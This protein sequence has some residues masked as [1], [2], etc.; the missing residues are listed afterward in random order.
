MF[1]Q[2][3]VGEHVEMGKRIVE[4]LRKDHFPIM[5]AFWYR[6]PDSGFWRLVIGSKLIDKIGGLEGYRRLHRILK[7][8]GAM[9]SFSGSISLFGSY[10]FRWEKESALGPGQIE[11]TP[12]WGAASTPYQEAYVYSL[13][14]ARPL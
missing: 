3:L 7:Q 4:A 9:T 5:G 12:S 11:A 14:S 6:M 1:I 8:L 10:D 13:K 2:I